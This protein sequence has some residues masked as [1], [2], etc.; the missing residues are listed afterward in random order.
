MIMMGLLFI[1]SPEIG[2]VISSSQSSCV[3]D[4]VVAVALKGGGGGGEMEKTWICGPPLQKR[5]W[6][7]LTKA[8][9]GLVMMGG[10]AVAGVLASGVV[11]GTG[12]GRV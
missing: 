9:V 8:K 12:G 2:T 3:G 11:V 10:V 4:V 5:Q 7:P 6:V 1:T